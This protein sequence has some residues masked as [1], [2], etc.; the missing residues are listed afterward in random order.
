MKTPDD[1]A[2]EYADALLSDPERYTQADWLTDAFLAGY[3]AA[4]REGGWEK[5]TRFEVI[6]E[7]GRYY[8]RWGVSVEPSLQDGGRTLKIFLRL[9]PPPSDG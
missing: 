2:R 8:A 6:D 1:M 5:V 7:T 9:R 4:Q 3:L